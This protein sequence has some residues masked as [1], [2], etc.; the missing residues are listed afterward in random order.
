MPAPGER[1]HGIFSSWFESAGWCSVLILTVCE[2]PNPLP[3]VRWRLRL[4]N[5]A[6]D[7]ALGTYNIVII[8]VL[9]AGCAAQN[10]EEK[11][12]GHK[13]LCGSALPQGKPAGFRCD[14]GMELEM[15]WTQLS[16][17]WISVELGRAARPETRDD[18]H[19]RVSRV[20]LTRGSD[21][22]VGSP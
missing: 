3:A 1:L 8:E 13:I 22:L 9:R 12:V 4:Y 20:A 17:R 7:L 19:G 6:D 2:R 5:A 18:Y 14:R 11:K 16:D 21:R 15:F 10:A